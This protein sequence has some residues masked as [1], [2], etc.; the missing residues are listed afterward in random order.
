MKLLNKYDRNALFIIFE[1]I[2]FTMVL[3]LY[4]P[5]IQMFAKRMGAGDIH[6]A[7]LSALPPL[8]A[9]FVLIPC[10][11]L[12]ERINKKKQTTIFLIFLNSL[13]YAV[14][15]FV[16]FI[17]HQAKVLVYILLISLMNLPGS[18]YITT[19]QSFYADTFS[20]SQ[21]STVYSL[22]SKYGAFFGLLTALLTGYILTKIPRSEEGRLVVY[23]V[24]YAVCFAIALL[25]LYFISKVEQKQKT[26]VAGD[27]ERQLLSFG[28]P[29]FRNMLANRG[30]MAFCLCAF[31]FHFAWQMGWPL[32]F[33]YNVDY[34]K[35]NEF[36][37]GLISVASGMT[38]FL[39]YSLWNRLLLKYGSRLLILFGAVGLAVNP[40]FFTRPVSFMAIV[41]VNI[42]VGVSASG[43]G[44][45]LFS[46]LL[47][48]LPENK[49]TVYISVFNTLT[50]I[51]GFISPFIGVWIYKHTNIYMAM[52][53]VGILRVTASMFY[54]V[55]WWYGRKRM[56]HD[57]RLQKSVSC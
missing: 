41:A 35:L 11:I 54:V 39:S 55:R 19:W 10:G 52:L 18:L 4:N 27:K 30:F 45:T 40:F 2:A 14:I 5:F 13:F 22:R 36:Q 25:Q 21:A 33:I 34:I 38:S 43:F 29:D 37:L 48:T 26:G 17:P 23:Q 3:N 51:T 12:I 47:E 46:G 49:K 1:G 16:P 6:I 57:A 56:K 50:S 31:V 42:F 20:G 32:F 15:A 7:L 8:V 28:L 9:I 24:F 53:I 44:L